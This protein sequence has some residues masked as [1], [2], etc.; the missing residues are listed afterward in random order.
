MHAMMGGQHGAALDALL[1]LPV[2]VVAFMMGV[3]N[4]ADNGLGFARRFRDS[5][6]RSP[7]PVKVAAL[8]MSI[9]ATVHLA[10]A[11]GHSLEQPITALLLAFDGLALAAASLLALARPRFRPAAA[12][13]LAMGIVAYG[14]YV[15]TGRENVDVVGV[16]TKVVEFSAMVLVLIRSPGSLVYIV[17]KPAAFKTANQRR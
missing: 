2:V 17:D 14:F 4:A 11:P 16:A 5:Y 6:L 15:A 13:L 8:L 1:Y 7:A 12:I 10:I 9:S 3:Q